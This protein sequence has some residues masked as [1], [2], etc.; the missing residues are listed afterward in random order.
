MSESADYTP[1][2]HWGGFDFKSAKRAYLDNVVASGATRASAIGLDPSSLVPDKIECE[3]ESPLI[4]LCDVT[5]S[6]GDWPA[7]IFSKLP[8]LEHEGKEYLG[9]D[10]QICFGAVGDA[11]SDRYPLQVRPFVKGAELKDS[12][13][14]LVVEKGGGGSSQ[15]SY[16]LGAVYFSENVTCPK[17][18]HKPILIF[19]GDEG[20]YPEISKDQA[21]KWCRV[22]FEKTVADSRIV[23]EKLKEKFSVYVVR[24]PY[25]CSDANRPSLD[26]VRIQQQ[27]VDFLGSDHV[28]S[29]PVADRVVDVIFGI[30]GRESGKIE[31]FEEELKTRQLKD[32]DGKDKVDVVMKALLTIHTPAKSMKKLP[33][34]SRAKSVT[35][36]RKIDDKKSISL[37]DD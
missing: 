22:N 34:P 21:N 18:I 10:F 6:M 9:D 31:Y 32:K 14:K 7:T 30:L 1:A 25:N 37:L 36:G 5:G 11:N 20:I 2:P 16:D 8:Y 29:L 24:K 26:E 28:V 4:I 12:L 33:P 19:I 17:A 15:E 23:F 3:A 35:R 27:W 13:E